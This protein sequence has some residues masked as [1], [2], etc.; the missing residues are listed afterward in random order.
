[1]TLRSDVC[2]L[3]DVGELFDVCDACP[4]SAQACGVRDNGAMSP[5]PRASRTY[6]GV[7]AAVRVARRRDQFLEAGLEL[8]GTAG[9][10]STSVRAVCREA[11]LSERYF[12]ES[13]ESTEALLIGVY[14]RCTDVMHDEMLV[15]LSGT[16]LDP[17]TTPDAVERVVRTTLE[18]VFASIADPRVLRVCWLEILG[19][20]PAVDA[21]YIAGIDRFAG[22]VAVL[23]AG[24]YDIEI[25]ERLRLVATALVGAVMTTA[26]RWYLDGQTE[27]VSTLVDANAIVF[28]GVAAQL[29]ESIPQRGD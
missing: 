25:D 27:P 3:P 15:A 29:G 28:A 13:F 14:Q 12:Y 4:T 26:V 1:M 10:S 7:P 19:V 24:L 16:D 23:I 20:G 2:D 6:G 18:A 22:T 21:T 9:Y 11:G 8:F 5:P 17:A